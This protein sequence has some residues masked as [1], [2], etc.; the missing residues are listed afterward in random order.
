MPMPVPPAPSILMMSPTTAPAFT[1]NSPR[2][3]IRCSATYAPGV[4]GG[5][6]PS[7]SF[8]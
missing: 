8:A 5:G 1:I 3:Q 2:I 6:R 4:G 7:Y